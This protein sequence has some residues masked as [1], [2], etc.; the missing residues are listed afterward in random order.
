MLGSWKRQAE[1]DDDQYHSGNA[2]ISSR[3]AG[4]QQNNKLGYNGSCLQPLSAYYLVQFSFSIWSDP[5]QENLHP[6][7][8]K[9]G[10]PADKVKSILKFV[11]FSLERESLVGLIFSLYCTLLHWGKKKKKKIKFWRILTPW[12]RSKSIGRCRSILRS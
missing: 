7:P 6:H 2:P 4:L 10:W 11:L 3:N 8:Q 1:S 5:N 12:R 9:T